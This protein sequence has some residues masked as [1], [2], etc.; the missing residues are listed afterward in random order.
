MDRYEREPDVDAFGEPEFPEHNDKQQR[1]FD[2]VCKY[3]ARHESRQF[4]HRLGR[5]I[6]RQV[7]PQGADRHHHRHFQRSGMMKVMPTTEQ[8]NNRIKLSLLGQDYDRWSL[9]KVDI[10]N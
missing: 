1:Q 10:N 9:A 8:Q 6:Q 2:V 5:K 7:Q 3:D 4:L